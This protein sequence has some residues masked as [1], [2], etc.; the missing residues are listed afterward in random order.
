MVMDGST[1]FV[2]MH[3]AMNLIEIIYDCFWMERIDIDMYADFLHSHIHRQ[4]GVLAV[5]LLTD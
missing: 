4:A 2:I 1:T 5:K 3:T